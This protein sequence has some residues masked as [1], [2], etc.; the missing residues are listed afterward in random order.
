MPAFDLNI[1][2]LPAVPALTTL[3]GRRSEI[4]EVGERLGAVR[5]L[6]LIGVGGVGKT[7]LAMETA[8]AVR[9]R[10]PDGVWL[11]DLAPVRE[12]STV[13]SATAT[14]LGFPDRGDKPAVELLAGQLAEHRALIL[15]DNCEH[16]GHACGELADTVLAAAP[17]VR[18]LA[19]SRRTLG[20]R[21]EHLYCVPPLPES[22][23]AELLRKRATEAGGGHRLRDAD[24]AA[25]ARLCSQLDG[26]PLAIQLAASRLRTLTV[27]QLTDRLA[28]RLETLKSDIRVWSPRQR[29]MRAAIEYSY[30][31]C[32][33]AERLLWKR[34]SV[35][36]GGFR[37]DAAEAVCSGDGIASAEVLDVL[38]R[39]VAQSVVLPQEQGGQ[40]R[41]QLLETI[42]Q[43]GR[44]RLGASGEEQRLQRRHRDYFLSLG[45]TV[46]D[47]W[48]G[49]GQVADLTSLRADHRNLVTALSFDGDPQATL[50]LATAL[51][52]HWCAGGFLADGRRCLERA[53]REAPDPT[54]AR[55]D[56]LWVA[57]WTALLQGDDAIADTWL[58]EAEDLARELGLAAVHARVRDFQGLSAAFKENW[59]EARVLHEA[60]L[61]THTAL[62]DNEARMFTF[63]RLTFVF[64]ALGDRQ[65]ATESGERALSLA[66]VCGERWGR[67]HVLWALGH[68]AWVHGD[69][70]T[71]KALAR[72]ACEYQQGF[73]DHVGTALK[74]EL[75]AW[76]TAS[77]GEHHRAAHLLGA[78]TTLMRNSSAAFGPD[79]AVHHAHCEEKLRQVLGAETYRVAFAAGARYDSPARAVEY[80][81][82]ST[83]GEL[84]DLAPATPQHRLARRELEVAALV[85]Q[86]M[87]N[88][89]IAAALILSLRTVDSH[90]Q[91][92]LVK[93]GAGNRAQIAAWWT[94]N[95]TS[96]PEPSPPSPAGH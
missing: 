10:F 34:L 8:F 44:E 13:A 25:V 80:A 95:R 61:A 42:R 49:P 16:L 92:V 21:S 47:R 41:Y 29:T 75:L 3:V 71:S 72:A 20:A 33:P 35:F 56:A 68:E 30:E 15:L 52:H 45:L 81:L 76:A 24:P 83:S 58:G 22:D 23:A 89:K 67:A 93:L 78:A 43:Y 88:R 74:L 91:N 6:T 37:L 96:L 70:D 62:E 69:L 94:A 31:L 79:T 38:D 26:L 77:A 46:A 7:R 5:L 36:A 84:D 66:D 73:N 53:L 57:A 85:A 17:G 48:S 27:E 87:S 64:A 51:R 50:R 12:P 60:A 86:G 54:P 39:L 28:E 59:E 55:A 1:G 18:F 2:N 19:T 9:D 65:R 63:L 90:V 4:A 32:E 40:P 14:A 11:V 82:D